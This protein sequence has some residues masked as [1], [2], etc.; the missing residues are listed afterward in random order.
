M[1]DALSNDLDFQSFNVGDVFSREEFPKEFDLSQP[2]LP[3]VRVLERNVTK[4]TFSDQIR[5][6]DGPRF[7]SYSLID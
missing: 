7:F 1:T 5:I 6:D 2:A 3:A 4:K